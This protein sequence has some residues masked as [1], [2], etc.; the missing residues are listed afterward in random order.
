[1]LLSLFWHLLLFLLFAANF[2]GPI[3]ANAEEIAQAVQVVRVAAVLG[4]A[5]ILQEESQ[6]VRG[7]AVTRVMRISQREKQ[8]LEFE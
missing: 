5:K 7:R 4:E 3:E 1:L 8:R 2:E 6:A